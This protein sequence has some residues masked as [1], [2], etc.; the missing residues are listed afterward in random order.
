MFKTLFLYSLV[1]AA[2]LAGSSF[3]PAQS[4]QSGQEAIFHDHCAPCHDN[5][6]TRAP[7]RASLHAMSP[8]F[9][10]QA[11]TSGIMA[12][13][14]SALSPAQR[15]SLAEYLTG[16]KI[17]GAMPMA[18]HCQGPPPAFSLT[19]PSFNGWGGNLESWR[20][21][22]KPGISPAQLKRLRVKW[23]FGFPGAVVAFS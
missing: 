22:P 16:R 11:L 10:V 18:G 5:P 4:A 20:Y 17:G 8:D 14:G 2:V 13:P 7:T 1:I 3:A 21:Q 6:A 12:G 15:A 9:I 23:A 19:G